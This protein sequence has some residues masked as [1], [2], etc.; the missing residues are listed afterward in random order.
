MV[1]RIGWIKSF[2]IISE[3]LGV[4]TQ[5]STIVKILALFMVYPIGWFFS[6][7]IILG[8]WNYLVTIAKAIIAYMMAIIVVGMLLTMAPIFISFILFQQTKS[9]FD[10]WIRMLFRYTLEPIML[11]AGLTFINELIVI[12][13]HGV[14]GN[15]AC[16]KCAIEF[17]IPGYGGDLF[18]FYFYMPWGYSANLSMLGLD[19]GASLFVSCLMFEIFVSLA[20][21]YNEMMPR[22][23]APLTMTSAIMG[24]NLTAT[25]RNATGPAD[26][27][28]AGLTDTLKKPFG[29]D[30]ASVDRRKYA[31]GIDAKANAKIGKEKA[32]LGGGA[33]SAGGTGGGKSLAAAATA[34]GASGGGGIVPSP[35]GEQARVNAAKE[36]NREYM[37][38]HKEMVEA[39]GKGRL[40]RNELNNS[41][42]G[43]SNPRTPEEHIAA[44]ER[45]NEAQ[46]RDTIAAAQ[47]K[48]ANQCHSEID[49]RYKICVDDL[50][51]GKD[52][53]TALAEFKEAKGK[54]EE[55]YNERATEV[56]N[57][58]DLIKDQRAEV[59]EGLNELREDGPGNERE[60]EKELAKGQR[61]DNELRAIPEAMINAIVE[62]KDQA[63]IEKAVEQAEKNVDKNKERG[64][65]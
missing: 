7:L 5:K 9:Y 10:T 27:A 40:A 62:G 37:D 48:I 44:Q 46:D 33:D 50:N 49:E 35:A 11:I 15:P 31:E 41:I 55:K 26:K 13:L 4:I 65:E 2:Q 19:F 6:V 42:K 63:G 12:A 21:D 8:A 57:A 16:W 45:Y 52:P 17:S 43:L 34:V 53:N 14:I 51:K 20:E 39:D 28:I 3:S 24:S 25:I 1:V 30:K 18:C 22:I 47:V 58:F 59:K 23:T 60:I 64:G 56:S 36:A 38:S 54:I 32:A 29:Y 61:A